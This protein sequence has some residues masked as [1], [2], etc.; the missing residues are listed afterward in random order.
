M[1]KNIVLHERNK[2]LSKL[3]WFS[4]ILSFSLCIITKKPL[5]TT[6]SIGLIGI[7]CAIII[8]ILVYRKAF[9]HG[10][11]YF[12]TLSLSLVSF[13]MMFGVKHITAYLMLYYSLI[14]VSLYQDMKPILLTSFINLAF[15]FYFFFNYRESMFPNCNIA[16]LINFCIYMII[17]TVILI[18][19]SKFSED[20]RKKA[21]EAAIETAKEKENLSKILDEIKNSIDILDNFNKNLKETVSVTGEISNDLVTASSQI[22]SGIAS[23]SVSVDEIN[24]SIT[25]TDHSITS[26]LDSSCKMNTLCNSSLERVNEG[27][28]LISNLSKQISNSNLTILDTVQLTNDLTSE[29]QKISS[30]LSTIAEISAQTNLLALNASIEAARAGEHGRGF[31]VVADEV[32]NLAE[33]SKISTEEITN[34]LGNIQNQVAMVSSHILSVKESI[35]DTSNSMQKSQD[36]FHSIDE[37]SKELTTNSQSVASLMSSIGTKSHAIVSGVTQISSTT[38]ENTAFVQEIAAKIEEQNSLMANL[39]A[40][41]TKLDS[42]IDSLKKI[43][44]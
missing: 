15:T 23:E 31:A 28:T 2:L 13:F 9:I 14:L 1:D 39:V 8:S 16:S 30:I 33:S 34:I 36:I 7:P 26:A 37:I 42:M 4:A 41:F 21:F 22:A 40:N 27:S 25:S 32:K 18:F 24:N 29:T 5:S 6:V 38:Q 43:S 20:L 3:F 17:I 12:V 10:T 44:N 19:Q 35:T 11:M